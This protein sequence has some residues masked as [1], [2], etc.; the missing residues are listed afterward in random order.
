MERGGCI[1]IMTNSYNTVYYI[2]VT[3][4]LYTR[5]IEHKQKNI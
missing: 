1:Y 3:S 5:V 2:G 4:D